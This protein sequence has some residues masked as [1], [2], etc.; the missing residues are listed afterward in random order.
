MKELADKAG[1][2]HD[3]SAIN[4]AIA[5]GICETA[6]H[7]VRRLSE[8]LGRDRGLELYRHIH[9]QA[10]G[11][12]PT[13]IQGMVGQFLRPTRCSTLVQLKDALVTMRQLIRDLELQGHNFREPDLLMGL[14]GLLPNKELEAIEDL[15]FTGTLQKYEST[16]TLVDRRAAQAHPRQREQQAVVLL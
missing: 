5:D 10:K 7:G 15:E 4:R 14:K 13:L 6:D 8:A 2:T 9:V 12:S 1:V 3:L 16:L 11:L